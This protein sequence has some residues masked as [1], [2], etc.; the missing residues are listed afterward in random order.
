MAVPNPNNAE[1]EIQRSVLRAWKLSRVVV[2]VVLPLCILYDSQL[3]QINSYIYSYLGFGVRP[4]P[5]HSVQRTTEPTQS[6]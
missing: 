6:H 5:F 1:Q 4:I 2:L 3:L